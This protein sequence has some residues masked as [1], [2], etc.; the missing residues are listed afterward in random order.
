MPC[1]SDFWPAERDSTFDVRLSCFGNRAADDPRVGP[2]PAWIRGV[3]FGTAVDRVYSARVGRRDPPLV[4][5]CIRFGGDAGSFRRRD[6]VEDG[7][8]RSALRRGGVLHPDQGIHGDSRLHGIP[9]LDFAARQSAGSRIVAAVRDPVRSGVCGIRRGKLLFHRGGWTSPLVLL[10][11]HL[12][13]ALLF[14]S[15]RQQLAGNPL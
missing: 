3:T 7:S 13:P 5:H 6:R 14:G 2:A 4:Q 1:S 11:G 8:G 12:S 15:Q 9:D 10:P